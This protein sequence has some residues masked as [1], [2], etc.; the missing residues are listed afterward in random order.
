MSLAILTIDTLSHLTIFI[1]MAFLINIPVFKV[2]YI[3]QKDKLKF[4][5]ISMVN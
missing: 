1:L 2:S 4:T 3:N 5:E